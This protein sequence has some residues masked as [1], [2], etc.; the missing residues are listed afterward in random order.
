[1]NTRRDDEIILDMLA[2]RDQ[3]KGP[4]EIARALSVTKGKVIGALRRVD[5]NDLDGVQQ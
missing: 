1:M 4:S 2:L 3:G 5:E